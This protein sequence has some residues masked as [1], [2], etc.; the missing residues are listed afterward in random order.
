ANDADG[1]HALIFNLLIINLLII[2]FYPLFPWQSVCRSLAFC[3]LPRALRG[4]VSVMMI[5]L[6]AL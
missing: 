2:D 3:I 5:C 6:G 4:N 1:S